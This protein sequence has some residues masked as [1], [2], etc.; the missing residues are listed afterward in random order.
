MT[1]REPLEALAVAACGAVLLALLAWTWAHRLNY[2]FD[3]EWMEGG[4]LAHAWRLRHGLPLY[5]PPSVDFVPFIY[6]PGQPALVAA[7]SRVFGLSMPLGR[8]VS[9]L[10]T[11][12][13]AA[14]LAFAL[15]P[16]GPAQGRWTDALAAATVFLGTYPH[17]GAFYDLVRP[18]ALSV[19]LLGWAVALASERSRRA[20]VAAGLLLAGATL[21]KHNAAIFGLPLTLGLAL[22]DRRAA[23]AFGVA[24]LGGTAAWFVPI[25]VATEG[26]LSTWL[27]EV[28]AA[29]R[30][31][32]WHGPIE[33]VRE[34]GT[35]LPIAFAVLGGWAVVRAVGA[36]RGP[37]WLVAGAPVWAGMLLA[38]AF[39]Y[40]PPGDGSPLVPVAY[41]VAY[42]AL[43]AGPL[44]ALLG[45]QPWTRDAVAVALVVGTAAFAAALMRIH[46]G[47]FVNVHTPLFWTLSWALGHALVAL[48]RQGHRQLVPAAWC[49]QL[50]WASVE[51]RPA[52]LIPTAADVA[53]GWRFVDRIR[54]V[55]GPVLSPFAPWLPVYAGK[56]PSLH[57]MGV[58]D[59]N[60]DGGPFQDDLTAL[61]R[62]LREQYWTLILGG[63][64]PLLGD[65]SV[66]YEP[67]APVLDEADPAFWP[68]T[69]YPARPGPV[70]VPREE[71]P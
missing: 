25:E 3:L 19:A 32:W 36:P 24:W 54:G 52:A 70:W 44:A 8:M 17:A 10:S 35:A 12:A 48:R 15:R 16:R 56:P 5:D 27:F 69:G 61:Q 30:M 71:R 41:A 21:A 42:W 37:L 68:R 62:G 20:A 9:I 7:L 47:G 28:P 6:P 67:D 55:D 59:C 63:N 14:A 64:R 50:L 4:M 18:D 60:Y 23:V 57:A 45:R 53:A 66:Y 11:L 29:H 2:P 49:I 38:W 34:W 65:F 31:L 22:R 46:D 1:R 51:L 40:H 43:A 33:S 13:A 26:R 39:T 58:W